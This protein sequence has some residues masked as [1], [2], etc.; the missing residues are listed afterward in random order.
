MRNF[1]QNAN[2][3]IILSP[4]RTTCA[5][6]LLSAWTSAQSKTGVNST[7]LLERV[8]I[9]NIQISISNGCHW[10]LNSPSGREVRRGVFP[11][12][13]GQV[14]HYVRLPFQKPGR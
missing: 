10:L 3:Y 2:T 14:R 13:T 6:A 4:Q 1:S 7:E 9:H 12:Q 8:Y 5:C 11:S